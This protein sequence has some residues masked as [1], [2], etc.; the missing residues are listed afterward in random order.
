MPSN[1]LGIFTLNPILLNQVINLLYG[2]Q[3]N[4]NDT[5]IEAPGKI[6]VMIAEKVCQLTLGGFTQVCHD[7]GIVSAEVTK[8]GMLQQLKSNLAMED[9]IYVLDLSVSLDDVE[10][11]AQLMLPENFMHEFIFTQTVGESQHREKDFWRKAIKTQV[12]D[13]LVTVS[14]TLPDMPLRVNEFMA[15][16]EGDTIPISDPTLV[17]VCLN[18]LKL[19]RAKAGQANSKRVAKILSQI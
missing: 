5:D 13:S 3:P 9:N 7:Y 17:Y 14:V 11:N 10:T 6:G 1:H 15:L 4:P 12:V 18:N 16:K 8:T 2:G 19:F